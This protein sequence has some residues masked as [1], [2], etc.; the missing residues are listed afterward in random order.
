MKQN[1]VCQTP[2]LCAK[3]LQSFQ[4]C[5]RGT[6]LLNRNYNA[7][8]QTI[9]VYVSAMYSTLKTLMSKGQNCLPYFH[10]IMFLKN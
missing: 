2:K 5:E 1:K 10:Y 8:T 7:I 9:L 4:I 6:S 3:H